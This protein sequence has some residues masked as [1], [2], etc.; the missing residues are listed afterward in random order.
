[1]NRDFSRAETSPLFAVA[2]LCLETDGPPR[3][4]VTID[5]EAEFDWTQP[6]SASNSSVESVGAQYRAQ[7]IFVRYGVVPTYLV[8][9]AVASNERALRTLTAFSEAAR[10]EI[11][12]HLNPWLTPPHE[13][14]VDAFHSYPGNLPEALERAKLECLTEKIYEGFGLRP[15]VYRAGRYGIGAN[16]S[17]TLSKLKYCVDLSVVPFTSFAA[18]GGPDFRHHDSRCYWF[19]GERPLLE[20]PV[21][22]GFAGWLSGL[23][24]LLYPAVSGE[25]GMALHLPGVLARSKALERIRLT[26]EGMTYKELQRITEAL[27]RHGTRLFSLYYHSP[28]LEPG[29][30]PYVRDREG[31]NVFLQTLDKYIRFFKDVLGGKFSTPMEIYRQYHHTLR[32]PP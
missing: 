18:D 9:F 15:Q 5:T 2:P 25:I 21:T 4:I 22:C 13:E 6:V 32:Q 17:R 12:A 27:F 10:C 30:T 20:I 14:P 23:G 28:S 1:M 7:E 11:G 3:L 8:D 16:T 26:P 24:R 19:G 29:N 31:L